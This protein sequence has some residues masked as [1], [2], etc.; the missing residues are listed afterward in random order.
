MGADAPGDY[1]VLRNGETVALQGFLY[2]LCSTAAISRAHVT[3]RLDQA[4]APPQ[5]AVPDY[6]VGAR[7]PEPS[8]ELLPAR[9]VADGNVEPAGSVSLGLAGEARER[10]RAELMAAELPCTRHRQR[11][12]PVEPTIFA[13]VDFHGPPRGPVRDPVLR[14]AAREA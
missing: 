9:R 14:S 12:R 11:V 3:A 7:G 5:R 8:R 10:L 2:L 6:G 1:G 13:T 4:Q